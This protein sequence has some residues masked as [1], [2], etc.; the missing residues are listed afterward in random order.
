M[1]IPR[2]GGNR[3]DD[4]H[5]VYNSILPPNQV[6]VKVHIA[7]VSSERLQNKALE[8]IFEDWPA[9]QHVC[10]SALDMVPLLQ[11]IL[12]S[13]ERLYVL[14]NMVKIHTTLL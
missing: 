6:S 2:G 12:P 11:Y 1:T 7:L 4:V 3:G 5:L 8:G 14:S 13:A 9:L 10:Q